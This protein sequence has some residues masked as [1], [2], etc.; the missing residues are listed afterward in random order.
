MQGTYA[1]I[2]HADFSTQLVPEEVW[3]TEVEDALVM[4]SDILPTGLEVGLLDGA[5]Q[6]GMRI[7][8]VGVGPVGLAALITSGT[9]QPAEL[10]AID[11]NKHRLETR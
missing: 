5:I 3:D 1:R 4:C 11:N 8:I 10:F 9:H 2:P 6:P 7:A